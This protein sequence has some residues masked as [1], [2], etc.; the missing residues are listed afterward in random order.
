[1]TATLVKPTQTP[2]ADLYTYRICWSDEDQEFVGTCAEFP[3]LSWLEP[4]PTKAFE[5]IRQVVKD[6][7][8]DMSENGEKIPQP[9]SLRS[10]SGN[11]QVRLTPSH[12]RELAIQAA[13]S[14][15]SLN[16][17]VAAKLATS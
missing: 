10:F 6:V 5:G 14:N 12:H 16:R 9:L 4:D 7:L 13:E 1:M 17:L 3:S 11:F 15:I 8:V 2:N